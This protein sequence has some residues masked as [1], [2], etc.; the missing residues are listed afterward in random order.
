MTWLWIAL[1]LIAAVVIGPFI[2]EVFRQKIDP[3]SGDGEV[4]D[5]SQGYTSYKWY[6]PVRGPVVVCIHGLT[7]PRQAFNALAE[8]MGKL[9]YRVLTYDLYGRGH[10]E[11]VKGAQD[12]DFHIQ[13]LLDLMEDQGIGDDVTLVGY[14]MGGMIGTA[15]TARYPER[16]RRLIMIASG[17][18]KNDIGPIGR[19][20]AR[21]PYFVH[22]YYFAIEHRALGKSIRAARALESEVPDIYD[23]QMAQ[24]G[25][26]GYRSAVVSSMNE[27]WKGDMEA[28][29]R[30]IAAAGVPVV[31]FFNDR[32]PVVPIEAV[33]ILAQWNRNA[34]IEVIP[35][36]GHNL[37][38]THTQE[39]MTCLSEILRE[40]EP[41]RVVT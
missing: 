10:S 8:R 1:A 21:T 24:L 25:L 30:A 3:Q 35:G 39:I 18:F 6:G 13:Q 14:S 29:T 2:G 34:K 31:A 23:I 22:W 36:E 40:E 41:L 5:L 37:P 15:F 20:I 12:R 9:G 28:E 26:K 27:M 38:F 4:V 32:D 17:G 16:V 19:W 11:A 33:G 7:T